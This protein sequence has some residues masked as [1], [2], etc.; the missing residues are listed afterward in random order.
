MIRLD[1]YS[2]INS[3]KPFVVIKFTYD[4]YSKIEFMIR[5][6]EETTMQVDDGTPLEAVLEAIETVQSRTLKF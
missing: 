6:G 4:D 1:E 5:D 2:Y 3:E